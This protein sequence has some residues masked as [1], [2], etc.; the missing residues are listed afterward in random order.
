[1]WGHRCKNKKL[2]SL[3]IVDDED[4]ELEERNSIDMKE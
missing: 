4:E 2:Y 3:Y 1:V